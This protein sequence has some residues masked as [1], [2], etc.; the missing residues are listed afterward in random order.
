MIHLS[1]HIKQMPEF[2]D[3][4]VSDRGSVWS[5]KNGR[6]R[7]ILPQKASN[8]YRHFTPQIADRKTTRSIHRLVAM[9]FLDNFNPSL[10]VDHINGN[11]TDNRVEN[12]RMVDAIDNSRGFRKKAKGKTSQYRGVHYNMSR[13]KWIAAVQS[14]CGRLHSSSHNSEIEAAVRWNKE[15][16]KHGFLPESLNTLPSR[17]S[18]EQSAS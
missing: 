12:L 15:A 4:W 14:V 1:N 6:V 5:Y 13:G 9:L 17:S 2:P 10:Y 16:L 7:K 18:L 3:Y 11:K 8:G